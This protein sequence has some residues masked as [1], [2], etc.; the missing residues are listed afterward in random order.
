MS[1]FN[2]ISQTKSE[3]LNGRLPNQDLFNSFDMIA[4][5]T[6]GVPVVLY[7]HLDSRETDRAKYPPAW[8]PS[9]IRNNPVSL[10]FLIRARNIVRH[11]YYQSLGKGSGVHGLYHRYGTWF[12]SML[13]LTY[14]F[15]GIA[16]TLS[17]Y[18]PC[19]PKDLMGF[20]QLES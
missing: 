11:M 19:L 15:E 13:P 8:I 6:G 16:L 18:S 7:D 2:V 9:F 1:C 20:I 12:D 5:Y 3:G 4:R 17:P 14:K 10:D